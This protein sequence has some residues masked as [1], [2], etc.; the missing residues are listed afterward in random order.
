MLRD[1]LLA[2]PIV[3]GIGFGLSGSWA[4]AGVL[5]SGLATVANLWVIM[6]L[7]YR[8][9]ASLDGEGGNLPLIGVLG[10]LKVPLA[11]VIYTLIA[12]TFG[13][14]SAFLGLLVLMA[15]VTVR[16]LKFLVQTPIPSEEMEL[17]SSQ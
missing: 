2:L 15:P 16:G 3:V 8:L 9:T 7:T 11:L 10:L 1:A 12:T 6:M 14:L 13:L 4:A 5:V 17:G